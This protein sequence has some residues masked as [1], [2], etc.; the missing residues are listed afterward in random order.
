MRE[1]WS[2]LPFDDHADFDVPGPSFFPKWYLSGIWLPRNIPLPKRKSPGLSTDRLRK[3]RLVTNYPAE[4]RKKGGDLCYDPEGPHHL[5]V[6]MINDVAVPD[7]VP[8]LRV[9]GERSAVLGGKP[10]PDPRHFAGIH[11]DCVLPSLFGCWRL[12]HRARGKV[13]CDIDGNGRA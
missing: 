12:R 2:H 5:V 4:T 9:K 3:G 6:F 1:R 13:G 11:L 7:I 10:Y 8:Y